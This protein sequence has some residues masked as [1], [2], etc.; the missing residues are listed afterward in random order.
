[1]V[2]VVK[3]GILREIL[4]Q[5]RSGCR[6]SSDCMGKSHVNKIFLARSSFEVYLPDFFVGNP[7]CTE[8]I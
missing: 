1:M 6:V 8:I 2:N 4:R 3:R 5:K 7:I